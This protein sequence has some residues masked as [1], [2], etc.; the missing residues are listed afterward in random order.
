MP[1]SHQPLSTLSA[2]GL[3][4]DFA[5]GNSIR[6]PSKSK[7]MGKNVYYGVKNIAPKRDNSKEVNNSAI[8]VKNG[9][10][11]VVPLQKESTAHV[12]DLKFAPP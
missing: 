9:Y 8:L 2:S 4:A 10:G 12:R 5:R 6:S 11:T 1:I 7:P 3:H